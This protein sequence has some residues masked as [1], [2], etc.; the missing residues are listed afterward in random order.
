MTSKEQGALDL[1][2][3]PSSP[4]SENESERKL[5]LEKPLV[6]YDLETTGLDF[7]NDRI[8]QFAFI[9][10]HPDGQ[11]EE[12]EELVNPGIPIPEESAKIHGITDS[13]VKDKPQF[14]H[15]APLIHDYLKN[16]DLAGYNAI[17]FDVPFLQAEMTR[18]ESALNL[19]KVQ[20][21]DPQ[22]IF[23]KKEPRDLAGA[24]R[25]YCKEELVGAHDAMADIRATLNVFKAQISHYDDLPNSVDQLHAFCNEKSD[26][27]V[28][29][30]RRFYWRSGE[31]VLAFGKHKSKSLKW[32]REKDPNY[33][34]WIMNGEF[35]EETKEVV[36]KAINGVFPEKPKEKE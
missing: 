5:Q 15:F 34:F 7:Q 9:K 32:L 23:H 8:V 22:I 3:A 19:E 11:E 17:R 13:I 33:L 35:S 14:N 24:Y 29:S 2:S 25:F 26:R 28:T 16:C 31:A 10:V 18:C 1:D 36:R 20:F 12:W 4:S 6:F 27:F 30:D 21:V